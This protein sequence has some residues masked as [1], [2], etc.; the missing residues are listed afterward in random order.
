MAYQSKYTG[1][2][3]DGALDNV[4]SHF[5]AESTEL[6]TFM[7]QLGKHELALDLTDSDGDSISDSNDNNIEAVTC[8]IDMEDIV[9][10]IDR[11]R[12][13]E[14]MLSNFEKTQSE[15]MNELTKRVD[16]NEENITTNKSNIE[17]L[18]SNV[19]L[20]SNY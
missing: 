7:L 1:K 15:I 14:T 3:I 12:A 10:L 13:L 2:E 16:A 5:F 9:P 18:K 6:S 20:D 17:T 19:L 8:F 11:I 4:Y